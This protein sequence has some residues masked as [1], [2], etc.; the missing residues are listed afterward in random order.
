MNTAE[1]G[2]VIIKNIPPKRFTNIQRF[3]YEKS[4]KRFLK[5]EY[6]LNKW[7]KEEVLETGIQRLSFWSALHDPEYVYSELYKDHDIFA[8]LI[9]RC[10]KFYAAKKLQT[11]V[12]NNSGLTRI[13]KLE[14]SLK[15]VSMIERMDRLGI[16]SCDFHLGNIGLDFG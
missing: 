9:A 14:L 3:N 2:K 12:H 13:Y 11:F 16:I 6:D 8:P 15:F 1:H 7:P 10:Q 4:V 5:S